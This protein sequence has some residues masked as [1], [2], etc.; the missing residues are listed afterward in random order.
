[1]IL[2]Y[3]QNVFQYDKHILMKTLTLLV[4]LIRAFSIFVQRLTR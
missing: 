4:G 3:A 1:M 2:K